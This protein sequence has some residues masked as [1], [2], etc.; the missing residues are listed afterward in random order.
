V[1]VIGMVDTDTNPKMVQYIIPGN[2]DA[3][4]SIKLVVDLVTTAIKEGQ[5][6]AESAKIK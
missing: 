5:S 6:K 1:P 2:D 4:K 3:L